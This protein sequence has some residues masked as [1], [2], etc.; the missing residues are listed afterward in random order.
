MSDALTRSRAAILVCGSGILLLSLGTRQTFGLFLPP[1]TADL[2]WGRETFAFAIALQN[3]VWGLAQPFVGAL[4]DR[5]GAGR[6]LAIGGLLYAIGLV[7][8]AYAGTGAEFTLSAGLV[9]GIALSGTSF[10][11]V[12]AVVGRAY[13]DRGRSLALGVVGAGG[14]LGQ[15][16]MLPYGQFLIGSVGWQWALIV[17][18]VSSALIVPL[19]AALAGR[20]T[21]TAG[22]PVLDFG[23][24]LREAAGHR[25]F[26][27][28][29]LS[30]MVCGFQTMFVMIHLPAFVIDH[31][32]PAIAGM[33]ALAI[34]GFMNI[35][36]SVVL[37]A[38]GGRWSKKNILTLAY[39][40]RVVALLALV[41]LPV[42]EASVYAFAF[43]MGFTW[44]GT[45]PL[46][47]G[48]VAQIFGVRQL[49]TLF[50]IAF[51]GH[52]VGAFLGAWLGGWV[53]DT[54]GSYQLIWWAAI[55]MSLAAAALCW[56]IDERRVGRTPVPAEA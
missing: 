47:N 38:L 30:F 7:W 48:L 11:V 49:G 43:I 46:T 4:A 2:G 10:G 34:V 31:G 16:A 5:Y 37:G 50:S 23:A 29:T 12:M 40:S 35:I 45:V 53:F 27:F 51:L 3:L 21:R 32:L 19:A 8:M 6:V 25:G 9:L 41:A 22:E 52:Q 28:L 55:A 33:T 18:A 13:S 17:M 36:G 1:M 20:P 44:L 14:S 26:Q 24:G 54:L 15:F 42:T 39:L 56:P